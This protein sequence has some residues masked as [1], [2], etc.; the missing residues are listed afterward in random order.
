[1]T[2][3]FRFAESCIADDDGRRGVVSDVDDLVACGFRSVVA[4]GIARCCGPCPGDGVASIGGGGGHSIG[5]RE[6]CGSED[7]VVVKVG[8]GI[9]HS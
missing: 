3:N 7:A 8:G 1:M 2:R 9:V 4:A 6:R 5:V